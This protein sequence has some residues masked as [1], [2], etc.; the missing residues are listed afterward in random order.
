MAKSLLVVGSIAL[1]TLRTPYG[2]VADE[3]GGS[4]T[5]FSVAASFLPP[6]LSPWGARPVQLCCQCPHCA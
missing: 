3:L 1:D 6:D 4:A 5:Y 2:E